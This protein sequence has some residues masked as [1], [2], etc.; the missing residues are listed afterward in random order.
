MALKTV[1]D[2]LA[3]VDAQRDKDHWTAEEL[4]LVEDEIVV[5]PS[6]TQIAQLTG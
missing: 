6:G 4:D 5:L 1:S 3:D 2:L